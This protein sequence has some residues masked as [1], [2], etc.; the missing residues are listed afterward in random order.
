MARALSQL[1]SN[2]CE[3]VLAMTAPLRLDHAFTQALRD[4]TLAERDRQWLANQLDAAVDEPANAAAA[5]GLRRQRAD[6]LARM[7]DRNRIFRAAAASLPSGFSGVEA[8]TRI[9]SEILRLRQTSWQR[10]RSLSDCPPRHLGT[11]REYAWRALRMHDAVP[12]VRTIRRALATTAICD[13]QR[14][15]PHCDQTEER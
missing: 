14:H 13:G 1:V 7:E 8:A 11:L 2:S 15:S 9:R 10:E 4:G 5:L 3:T 12:S 6:R